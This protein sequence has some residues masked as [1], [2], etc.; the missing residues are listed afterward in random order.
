MK[1]KNVQKQIRQLIRKVEGEVLVAE[2]LDIT[3][4]YIKMLEK[5]REC[6]SAL[7]KIID[8]ALLD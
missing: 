2:K 8:L 5:G 6:S 4:R 3:V 7:A 1:T